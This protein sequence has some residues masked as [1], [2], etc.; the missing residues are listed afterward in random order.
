MMLD[1]LGERYGKLPSEV[2]ELGS[3]FDLWVFDVAMGYRNMLEKRSRDKS[4][5]RTME[6][7][8]ASPELI[9]KLEEYRASKH[10]D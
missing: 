3:T 2:L 8:E 7:K 1:T 9:K 5:G 6:A 10:N 4:E